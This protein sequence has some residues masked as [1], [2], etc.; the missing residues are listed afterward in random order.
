MALKAS[1]KIKRSGMIEIARA[2]ATRCNIPPDMPKDE[3][4]VNWTQNQWFI[5]AS[6]D[7][8]R[9][10]FYHYLLYKTHEEK[11][12]LTKKEREIYELIKNDC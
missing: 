4:T 9:H 5:I 7:S 12:R 3:V 8:M 10:D 1:S 6:R 11:K 2:K